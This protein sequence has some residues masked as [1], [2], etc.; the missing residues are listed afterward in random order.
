MKK[1][2]PLQLEPTP[3]VSFH[4]KFDS[5]HVQYSTNMF[6][7]SSFRI[8]YS[9]FSLSLSSLASSLFRADIPQLAKVNPEF[10]GVAVCTI[11]GQRFSVGDV[12]VPFCVQSC[13]KVVTYAI[14]QSLHGPNKVHQHVGVEPSGRAFNQMCLDERNHDADIYTIRQLKK[15]G[16]HVEASKINARPAIPHNPCINAG[17]I[18]CASLVLPEAKEDVRFDFVMGIWRDLCGYHPKSQTLRSPTFANSTYL[19]ERASADRN[20]CLGYMMREEGAFPNG[21]N[22][23]KTLE[24]YFMYCSIECSVHTLSVVAGTFANGGTCPVTGKKVFDNSVVRNCLSVM[25]TCGMY[26]HIIHN[27]TYICSDI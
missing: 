19:S 14:A 16:K 15:A 22:I 21:T 5:Y 20:F 3:I 12:Q 25:Q 9:I 7:G 2:Y 13:S 11:D 18:M 23:L 4:A 8:S 26:V 24:S 17:A 27:Y 10:F 6:H 1:H